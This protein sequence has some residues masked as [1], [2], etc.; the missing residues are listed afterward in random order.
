MTL[1]GTQRGEVSHARFGQ[2][3][4]QLRQVYMYSFSIKAAVTDDAVIEQAMM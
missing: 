2:Y 3:D 4:E 1:I